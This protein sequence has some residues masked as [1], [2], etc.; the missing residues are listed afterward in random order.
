MRRLRRRIERFAGPRWPAWV[1]LLLVLFICAAGFVA[2][3][4]RLMHA[5]TF[6]AIG[7]A[8]VL[9]LLLVRRALW[10]ARLKREAS[11]HTP[12]EPMI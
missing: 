1:R 2:Y 4:W 3:H 9:V 5:R 10:R 11:L 7:I 6:E 8:F 12:Q